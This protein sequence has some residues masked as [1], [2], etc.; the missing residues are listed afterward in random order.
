MEGDDQRRRHYDQSTYPR[1]YVPQYGTPGANVSNIQPHRGVHMTENPD[2]FRQGQLLT[3]RTPTSIPMGAGVGPSQDF[4]AFAYSQAQQYQAPQMQP[5]SFP[6]Q[7]EYYDPQRQ[8]FPQHPSQTMYNVPQQ[9]QSQSPYSMSQ[10][11]PS[12]DPV[13]QYQPRQTAA[14]EVLSSQFG[15]PQQYYSAADA[16]ATNAP[17]LMPQGYQT[18]PYQQA[19]QYNPSNALG[20]STLASPYPAISSS[21]GQASSVES[22]RQNTDSATDNNNRI[23]RAI[24]ETNT[25]TSRGMLVQAGNS[26]LGMTDW[27]LTHAVSLGTVII[28]RL[29]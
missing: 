26:L 28:I 14:T 21:T 19:F 4:G 7:S 16:P 10:T 17:P 27:L 29:R 1:G 8:R 3:T 25:N 9:S 15:M 23:Y 2:Q 22:P 11:Q 20:R 13:G 6:Y 24:R 12:Y 18:T 5:P